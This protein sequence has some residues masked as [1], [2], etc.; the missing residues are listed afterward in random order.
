MGIAQDIHDALFGRSGEPEEG[1]AMYRAFAWL[2]GQGLGAND[3]QA[4]ATANINVQRPLLA[5]V[6]RIL[7]RITITNSGTNTVLI[8]YNG[9][10]TYPLLSGASYTATWKNPVK[11]GLCWNDQGNVA[12]VDAIS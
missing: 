2:I 10:P 4:P 1:G 8:G 11:A 7:P 5:A 6:N 9:S 12:I 3:H